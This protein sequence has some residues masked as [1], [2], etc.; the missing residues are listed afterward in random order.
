MLQKRGWR[1]LS[2]FFWSAKACFRF[3]SSQLAGGFL[4][5]LMSGGL[6]GNAGKPARGKAK[7][8]LRTPR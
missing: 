1:K 6:N 4:A 8:S 7:A 3:P 2:P 5:A